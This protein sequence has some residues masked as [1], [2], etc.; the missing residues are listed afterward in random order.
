[1]LNAPHN[2]EKKSYLYLGPITNLTLA[3]YK[4]SVLPIN[5]KNIPHVFE[6]N[7]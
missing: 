3:M 7:L 2:R 1:M 5:K 6:N 4:L